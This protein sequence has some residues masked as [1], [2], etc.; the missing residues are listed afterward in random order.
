METIHIKFDELA[1]MTSKHDSLEPIFQRFINDDSSAE[2][3]NIPSKEDLDNLFGPM[4]KEYFEKRSFETCI[5]SAA[6]QVHNHEESPLTSLI[7]VEEHEAP[8]IVTTSDEQT[9]PIFFNV[10]NELNQ[11]DSPDF[12][13]NTIF[14]PYDAP[15]FEDAESSTTALD[16]LNI[17]EFY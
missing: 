6:Q 10:A 8:P 9:S 7:V 12:D 13:G 16:P 2:S 11:E 3:M 15:N 1:S 4:Y 5:N 17:H 14:S